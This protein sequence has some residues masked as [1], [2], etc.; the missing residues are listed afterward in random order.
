MLHFIYII[1]FILL[2]LIIVQD[3]QF[4]AISW[5]WIPLLFLS[6]LIKSFILSDQEMILDSI[7]QNVLFIFLQI[8]ILIIYF[9]IKR[10]KFESVINSYIGWGDILFFLAIAP[11]LCF[12]N[13]L[14]FIV[15][16]ILVILISYSALSL[17][18]IKTD[19]QIPLAGLQSIFLLI[20][21]G[22]EWVF[23]HSLSYTYLPLYFV[24]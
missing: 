23:D 13:F 8:T 14:L 19:K 17:F 16:S 5:I 12:G 11:A 7:L 20:W 2:L 6:V 18:K 15:F 4:R 21:L 9:S 22:I 3:F 10:K 1:T 24:D